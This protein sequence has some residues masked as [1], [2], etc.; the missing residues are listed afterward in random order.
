MTPLA[1]GLLA[2]IAFGA[3]SVG[4]M[5][6]L[7][8]PDKRA[9]LLGAFLNRFAIGLL[10]PL[11][12]LELPGWLLGLG[13]GILLSLPD[14][15]ITKAFAPIIGVGAVGGGIIGWLASHV[16]VHA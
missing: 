15:I 14:A 12:R 11:I 4:M 2:G 10:I 13:L 6:P 8:F 16:V 5:L 3:I 1:Y 9:A 7:Q